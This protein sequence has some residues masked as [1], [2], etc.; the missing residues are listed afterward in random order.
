MSLEPGAWSLEP[1]GSPLEKGSFA[2]SA[3]LRYLTHLR[4]RDYFFQLDTVLYLSC[5]APRNV[6]SQNSLLVFLVIVHRSMTQNMKRMP[7]Q[8]SNDI[9]TGLHKP[10]RDDEHLKL[11][12]LVNTEGDSENDDL[13]RPASKKARTNQAL[14][15]KP[16]E[17]VRRSERVRSQRKPRVEDIDLNGGK[18]AKKPSTRAKAVKALTPT[19]SV[20]F[21]HTTK[22]AE[23]NL[24]LASSEVDMSDDCVQSSEPAESMISTKTNKSK[25]SLLD[26]PR[27]IRQEIFTYL[28]PYTK[29]DE[30]EPSGVVWVKRSTTLLSVC[31]QLY[32]EYACFMYMKNT[33]CF[34]ITS[35]N[36]YLRTWVQEHGK[37]TKL[38][39]RLAKVKTQQLEYMR[40]V[41]IRIELSV[42]ACE[43]FLT[44]ML[45]WD[46]C[47]LPQAQEPK[48]H[49]RSP[50]TSR[51]VRG[52]AFS[53]LPA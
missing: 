1:A 9:S 43:A 46:S 40:N 23:L 15:S 45:I 38:S 16:A 47:N 24:P 10:D 52:K 31:K 41:V 50:S 17:Q 51:S 27:E 53:G 5:I 48:C 42:L 20:V 32:D 29:P 11:L 39:G 3:G 6:W 7:T 19:K 26:L 36:I 35:N 34:T 12:D 13:A 14:T 4:V 28:L 33:W 2:E 49:W 44:R 22:S 30:E 37:V 21:E 25:L 18:S 8:K